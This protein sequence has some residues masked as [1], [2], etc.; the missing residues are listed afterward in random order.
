MKREAQSAD[1]SS[2]RGGP[3]DLAAPDA[4][5][6]RAWD[7]ARLVGVVDAILYG[8]HRFD[9]VPHHA[10]ARATVGEG[11]FDLGDSPLSAGGFVPFGEAAIRGLTVSQPCSARTL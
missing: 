3:Q 10:F 7:R 5:V 8:N 11:G 6:G 2:P 9:D 4:E 1:Q